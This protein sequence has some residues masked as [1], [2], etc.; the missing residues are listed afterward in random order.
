[1]S[2]FN[3]EA[4]RAQFTESLEGRAR[5]SQ[6][7]RAGVLA[8]LREQLQAAIP[9]E[10]YAAVDEAAQQLEEVRGYLTKAETRNKELQV[11]RSDRDEGEEGMRRLVRERWEAMQYVAEYRRAT[12]EAQ[13]ELAAAQAALAAAARHIVD[14]WQRQEYVALQ[15]AQRVEAAELARLEA[16]YKAAVA[17]AEAPGDELRAR[18]NRL[19][20]LAEEVGAEAPQP[21]TLRQRVSPAGKVAV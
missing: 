18:L 15:E 17:A 3:I 13:G 1:M 2:Q 21:P 5:W 4:L 11:A 8:P 16:E 10:L 20:L 12:Q 14:E 9:A 19:R 7:Q 6:E